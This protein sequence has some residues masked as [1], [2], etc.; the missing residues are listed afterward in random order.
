[1]LAGHFAVAFAAKRLAP[2]V[3]L[4]ALFVAAQLLDLLWPWFVIAGLER[5]SLAPAGSVTPLVFDFFPW[6]HSLLLAL[7][8]AL[9]A[10][11]A[12]ACLVRDLR[13]AWVIGALVLSHWLLDFVTHLPDLQLVP[14][15]PARFGLGLWNYPLAALGLEL[16]MLAV[17]AAFYLR[18][19][20]ALRWAGSWGCWLLIAFIAAIQLA[21]AFGPPP[22][23]TMAVIWADLAMWLLVLWA[24][25][26]DHARVPR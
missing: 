25:R 4:G 15:N 8:W 9:V 7:A 13:G 3:S 18:G 24:W 14:G 21:N 6:S 11:G 10:G 12:Y 1:M 17:G 20:R 2:R 23:G 22:P 16:A 5:L 26:S 19:T